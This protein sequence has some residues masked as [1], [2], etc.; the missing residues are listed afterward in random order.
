MSEQAKCP[1]CG[2]E[3]NEND[4]SLRLGFLLMGS[5]EV[6]CPGCGIKLVA[7]ASLSMGDE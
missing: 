1:E 4:G 5:R 3:V 7:T 2:A 6:T